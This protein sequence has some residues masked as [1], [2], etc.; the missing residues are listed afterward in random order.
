MLFQR[1]GSFA[2]F[3]CGESQKICPFPSLRSRGFV[4]ALSRDFCGWERGWSC[5]N[6]GSPGW[7]WRWRRSIRS[8][9][10]CAIACR[11]KCQIGNKL[12]ERRLP[13]IWAS[14]GTVCS[15]TLFYRPL[16]LARMGTR[17]M[18]SWCAKTWPNFRPSWAKC[19]YFNKSMLKVF[20]HSSKIETILI[21]VLLG[22]YLLF[23][24]NKKKTNLL[25]SSLTGII[26]SY[27][28]WVQN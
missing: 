28:S 3:L 15:G 10:C 21:L 11:S 18:C 24:A 22:T 6:G 17:A 8:A 19:M 23:L 1:A 12:S 26:N 13:G 5:R 9:I 2:F 4:P 25:E 14:I 16:V 7:V 20:L 27:W